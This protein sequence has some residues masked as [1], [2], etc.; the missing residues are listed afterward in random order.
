MFHYQDLYSKIQLN[1]LK[2]NK[3]QDDTY[4]IRAE[5]LTLTG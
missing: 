1:F 2:V 3:Y 4:L 5:T